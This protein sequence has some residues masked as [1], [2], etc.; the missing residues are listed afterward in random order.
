MNVAGLFAGIGGFELGLARAN[1]HTRLLCEIDPGA[2]AVLGSRFPDV[3]EIVP[4]VTKME[5]MP[6]DVDLV[7]AGF[8]LSAA[9]R[10]GT[11][12]AH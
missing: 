2:L 1:H 9:R 12:A 5:K 10:K 8:P 7:V 6:R 11:F 4:D 3:P